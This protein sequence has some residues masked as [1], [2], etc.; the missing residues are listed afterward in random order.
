MFIHLRAH[1]DY[2]FGFSN[3][4]IPDLVAFCVK[5]KMPAI[6]LANK[7][8]LFGALEFAMTAAK[9]GIQ[10]IIG[11]S[12]TIDCSNLIQEDNLKNNISSYSQPSHLHNKRGQGELLLI[13]KNKEGYQNLLALVS[14]A[15]IKEKNNIDPKTEALSSIKVDKLKKSK[16]SKEHHNEVIIALSLLQQRAQG[17][18]V[19]W[20]SYESPFISDFNSDTGNLAE[21]MVK[22]LL[23]FQCELYIELTRYPNQNSYTQIIPESFLL[24]LAYKYN[25]PLVATNPIS[26]LQPSM[27]EACDALSCII[28]SRYILEDN[29]PKI[30]PHHYFKTQKEME[31]LFS[32]LPEAIEN[33]EIIARKCSFMPESHPA[34]LPKFDEIDEEA[35]LKEQA[36]AGL[37]NRL[38]T[39]NEDEQKTYWQRLEFELATIIRM[40]F[41][42]YFLIVSDFIRWSKKQGIPVGP[43]RGSGAGSL[44]A[45]ALEITDLDPLEFG[46]LFE[47]FLNPDR[48][49]LPD[50][51]IDF[52]QSRRDEVIQYIRQKYGSDRVA[53]IITFGKLQARAVLRDVGRVLQMPYGLVDRICKMVPNNPAHPITL[54][55]AI[56]ID[57]E[58]QRLNE[59]EPDVRKLLEISLQLEGANRHVSTHAAGMIIADRPLVQL[60]ALYKTPDTEVPIIQ[61]S[62]KYAEAAGL[63]KFDFLGL[64]TLTVVSETCKLIASN[65]EEYLDISQIS[66][67]DSKTFSLL[68]QG[69]TI[70]IFQFEGSGMRE[71]IKNLKPD[72][73][74][75]L[76]ALTSLYRPGPLDNIP[77]YINRKH[78]LEPIDYI[79]PSLYQTL[80]ETYGIIVYQEQVMQI[81]QVLAGYSLGEADLLRRAMGKKNKQEMEAQREG[82]VRRA[83]AKGLSKEQAINIF[84]LVDKFASYGF[85]KSHAA[86]Y[87]VISYQTAYLKAN[88]LI[89]FLVASI[90]YEIDDSDK[91]SLFCREAKNMD[92]NILPPCIQ[93]SETFFS[94]EI[95]E[96]KRDIRFGLAGIKNAGIKI[97]DAIVLERKVNGKYLNIF[98]FIKRTN[99]F[100]MNKRLLESLAKAG[101]LSTIHANTA[102]ILEEVETLL[103][104]ETSCTETTRQFSLFESSIAGRLDNSNMPKL[105]EVA[106]F[107]FRQQITAE[108]QALGFYLQGHPLE[109]YNLRLEKIGVVASNEIENFGSKEGTFIK[110]AG[111]IMSRKIR[112]KKEG[113]GKFAFIQ[114]SDRKGIIDSSIFNDDIIYKQANLLEVGTLVLCSLQVR[115]DS[116][117]IRSTIEKIEDL[118]SVMHNIKAK[119][120]AYLHNLQD[121][122]YLGSLIEDSSQ[123]EC[124]LHIILVLPYDKSIIIR[125]SDSIFLSNSDIQN[126][127]RCIKVQEVQENNLPVY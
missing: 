102:Q 1:S 15:Y 122:E 45:W 49:S 44:V 97:I 124:E 32:D 109:P 37:K 117:G 16:N 93:H 86:A 13:A 9:F 118:E 22:T 105:K 83:I 50:F 77:L 71:T 33:T 35:S 28:H 59:E 23:S 74:N 70:G 3:I 17:L 20:G 43:G 48:V 58:M 94:I 6:C 39:K 42:G 79:H 63:M 99:P 27:H 115:K 12:L 80:V 119:Y 107:D 7:N 81:A 29:R 100:G 21:L 104:L 10:P 2:Y 113:K 11:C 41:P 25:I 116:G 127:S 51:D 65:T 34:L 106:L 87:S 69:K 31:E 123:P 36:Y 53:H 57:K 66:Y 26:F 84:D 52:C 92:I 64:K 101:A 55:E 114:I 95:S 82:F 67:H 68:T 47:R 61:Y 19:L 60:V 8:N 5:Q 38:I 62:M 112:S 73:I 126:L 85:N 125:T 30:H 54:K 40:G 111:V 46:L 89:E 91:I 121:L 4:K 72:H 90:N 75:D 24:D 108:Y 98:D 120:I 78:G 18:I 14:A 88:Y 103:H 110:V 56:K 96:D 76:I